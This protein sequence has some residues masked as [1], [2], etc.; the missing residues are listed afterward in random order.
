VNPIILGHKN[1]KKSGS[2]FKEKRDK[3]GQA[4]FMR[5]RADFESQITI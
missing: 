5:K 4:G 1:N 3:M 2:V